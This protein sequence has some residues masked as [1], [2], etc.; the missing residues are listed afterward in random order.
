MKKV[1]GKT[2]NKIWELWC[3]IDEIRGILEEHGINVDSL[4]RDTSTIWN[5]ISKLDTVYTKEN[6][7]DV[8][9]CYLI[10]K[11]EDG[12]IVLDTNSNQKISMLY[13]SDG[14]KTSIAWDEDAK[15]WRFYAVYAPGI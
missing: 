2:K 10:E 3:M 1:Y 12:R 4:K 9:K 7:I 8:K 11:D 5:E 14:T 13:D 6:G 15:V